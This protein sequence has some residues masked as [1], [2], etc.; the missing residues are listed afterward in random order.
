MSLRTATLWVFLLLLVPCVYVNNS[1][2]VNP[3]SRQGMLQAIATKGSFSIDATH[4]KTC[5]KAQSQGH[6]YSD[7]APGTALLALPAY[8]LARGIHAA[9]GWP[10]EREWFVIGWLTTVGSV[11]LLMAAGGA[12]LFALL[13]HWIGKRLALITVL[14]GFLGSSAFAYATSLF[15]HAGSIGLLSIALW[16]VEAPLPAAHATRIHPQLRV[17]MRIVCGAVL[18]AAA[19]PIL[20]IVIAGTSPSQFALFFTCAAV[21][22]FLLVLVWRFLSRYW[23]GSALGAA[24]S[25]DLIAGLACGFAICGEYT[26]SLVAGGIVLMALLKSWKRALRLTVA[27]AFPL[28]LLFIYNWLVFGAPLTFSY[29]YVEGFAEMKE[30]FFGIK[31]IPTL[32]TVAFLLFSEMRGLLFWTPFFL[33][34]VGGLVC[35]LRQSPARFLI[36]FSVIALHIILISGYFLP[37]GGYALGPRHLAPLVPFLTLLAGI[38]LVH[39]KQVGSLLALLSVLLTGGATLVSN[40]PS[41]QIIYPLQQYYWPA[42]LSGGLASNL[43]VTVG[44]SGVQSAL[45]IAVIVFLGAGLLW[46][47][48]GESVRI[49]AIPKLRIWKLHRT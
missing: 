36:Y 48:F 42:M 7:K 18:A 40:I 32:A 15:S 6:Y 10:S 14:G 13:S 33:L 1:N 49:P 3:N 9:T 12:A 19:F 21:S 29:A 30:G 11:A 17:A 16:A 26:V 27:A 24:E 45:F 41:D 38:A 44:L 35:V 23:E 31:N 43:G 28:S 5:D 2:T 22:G 20:L 37:S 34:S 47:K 46:F 39:V 8:T 25:R 4:E